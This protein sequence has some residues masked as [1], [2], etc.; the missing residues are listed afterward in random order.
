MRS[1]TIARWET[2]NGRWYCELVALDSDAYSVRY[3]GG[4][5]VFYAASGDEA[6]AQTK[7]R[8][9]ATGLCLPDANKTPLRR[10]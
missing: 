5:G 9:I 10:V 2:P 7:D 8:Y 6:I 3:D 4:G 1:Q